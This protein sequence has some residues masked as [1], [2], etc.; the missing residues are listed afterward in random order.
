MANTTLVVTPNTESFDDKTYY[1]TTSG[2]LAYQRTARLSF[3]FGASS[4][5]VH[6]VSNSLISANGYQARTDVAYRAT[7]RT[8][9]GPY[10]AY[11]RY[12]YSG[13]FGD[14]DIHTVG[15]NY[16]IALSKSTQ[17]RFRTGVTRLE[18]RGLQQVVLDPIVAQILGTTYGTQRYYAISYLP[19]VAIDISRSFRHSNFSVSY[20][21]GV[22]P[23]NGIVLTSQR[24]S[25]SV[26][27]SYSG[28]R[29]YAVTVSAGHDNLS[30]QAQDIGNYSSYYGRT[31]LSRQL[32]HNVQG[33]FSFDYRKVGFS[34]GQ[35]K[36]NQYR[37]TVGLGYA[38]GLGPLKFW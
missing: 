10:Y 22:S 9:I 24:D 20:L 7:K 34:T 25:E 29:R 15:L 13:T 36:K 4:F 21:R 12:N 26:N 3:D 18:T 5:Y 6:R 23:G 38:P 17:F 32:P 2:D 19:D 33:L 31:A 14:T 1:A 16:S 8:T 11:S 37:I 35:Y 28:V 27:Y 30:S